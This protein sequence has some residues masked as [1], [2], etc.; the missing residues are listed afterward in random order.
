MSIEGYPENDNDFEKML[1]KTT[2]L[3]TYAQREERM[4]KLLS[5]PKPEYQAPAKKDY[6][7]TELHYIIV[8]DE[9][10]ANESMPEAS[11]VYG[12]PHKIGGV[13]VS[14]RLELPLGFIKQPAKGTPISV[15]KDDYPALYEYLVSKKV[16][17][18]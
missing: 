16:E 7:T 6:P 18:F 9:D 14:D 15:V 10:F 8:I 2:S 3:T 11:K 17:N 4:N 5:D 12:S 1:E 13:L